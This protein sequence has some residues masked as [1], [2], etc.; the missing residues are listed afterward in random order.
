MRIPILAFYVKIGNQP[1]L[2]RSK[3]YYIDIF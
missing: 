1:N 3:K 2:M